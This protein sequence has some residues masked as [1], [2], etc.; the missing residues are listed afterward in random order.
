[1][2]GKRHFISGATT[3]G[4]YCTLLEIPLIFVPAILWVVMFF[5]LVPDIDCPG[6]TVT[7]SLPVIGK[8]ISWFIRKL[9]HAVYMAT[10]GPR[11]EDWEGTHRHLSHTIV[12]ALVIGTGL[13]A[14][15]LPW[16]GP[17]WALIFGGAAALGCWTHCLGDSLTEMGCPWLWPLPI[18]GETW[19]EIRTPS[20][21]R[22]H[23]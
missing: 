21:I 20:L 9:S 15:L 16:F 1:M 7:K 11:D 22:F 3:G 12:F 4:I 17:H 10:K 14:V 2:M 18:A 23:T 19:Y 13:G 5:A 8:P 6:S